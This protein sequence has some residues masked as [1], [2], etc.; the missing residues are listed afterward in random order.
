V[1]DLNWDMESIP[2]KLVEAR[3]S[4]SRKEEQR[5]RLSMK[6]LGHRCQWLLFIIA[7]MVTIQ[8]VL[9]VIQEDRMQ[10]WERQA[11]KTI[12]QLENTSREALDRYRSLSRNGL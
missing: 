11:E 9:G 12:E 10:K 5:F 8:A 3:P 1:A 4:A 6:V 7:V 2:P